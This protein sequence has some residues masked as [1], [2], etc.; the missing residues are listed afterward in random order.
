MIWGFIER[1]PFM[2]LVARLLRH[3]VPLPHAIQLA[4][5]CYP[6][7]AAVEAASHGFTLMRSRVTRSRSYDLADTLFAMRAGQPGVGVRAHQ[8]LVA[9]YGN[10]SVAEWFTREVM[11][12]CDPSPNSRRENSPPTTATPNT[13]APRPSSAAPPKESRPRPRPVS[14]PVERGCASTKTFPCRPI[15]GAA[16]VLCF[17]IVVAIV[18]WN[19]QPSTLSWQDKL[20]DGETRASDNAM[21]QTQVSAV[22]AI[23]TVETVSYRPV[24][25]RLD[26]NRLNVT[27]RDPPRRPAPETRPLQVAADLKQAVAEAERALIGRDYQRAITTLQPF[28]AATHPQSLRDS[29]LWGRALRLMHD[30]HSERV[31][32]LAGQHSVEV[33]LDDLQHI[34]LLRHRLMKNALARGAL[35]EAQ[36]FYAD[37]DALC[38]DI[39]YQAKIAASVEGGGVRLKQ[40]IASMLESKATMRVQLARHTNDRLLWKEAEKLLVECRGFRLDHRELGNA[41]C[42]R[43][44]KKLDALREEQGS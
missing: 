18:L 43:V 34:A 13:A 29:A 2:G 26:A 1:R 19:R 17:V 28:A 14:Q 40:A 7:G 27:Q 24:P 22:D 6:S 21:P 44:T 30:A 10:E 41:D 38:S 12:N 23:A 3:G 4:A 42:E 39:L 37:A 16:A 33:R 25:P 5:A 15:S 32:S 36:A 20:N 31:S 11:G 8:V 35:A 9:I